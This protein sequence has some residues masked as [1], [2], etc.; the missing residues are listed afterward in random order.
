[1]ITESIWKGTTARTTRELKKIAEVAVTANRGT[2][3]LDPLI[4]EF[5]SSD[6]DEL[7][8]KYG[9]LEDA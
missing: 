9:E 7:Y 1:M 6:L 4:V 2:R 8:A 3:G 5:A